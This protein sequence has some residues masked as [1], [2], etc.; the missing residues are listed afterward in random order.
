MDPPPKKPALPS[1][2]P[3]SGNFLQKMKRNQEKTERYLKDVDHF[4]TELG[5]HLGWE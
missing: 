1:F 3:L 4:L 2:E 5:D